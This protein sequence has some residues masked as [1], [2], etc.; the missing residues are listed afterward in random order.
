MLG[1]RDVQQIAASPARSRAGRLPGT[2]AASSADTTR[3]PI[4]A[5]D[6]LLARAQFGSRHADCTYGWL[7]YDGWK[8][9]TRR[10]SSTSANC[11]RGATSPSTDPIAQQM[12]NF[13][14][15]IGDRAPASA[16]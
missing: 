1:L 13:V 9:T 3:D 7:A 12:V 5:E 6:Q 2:P 10:I 16:C 14:Y 8:R 11:C 15:A 4:A